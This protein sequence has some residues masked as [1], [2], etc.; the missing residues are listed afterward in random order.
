MKLSN[1]ATALDLENELHDV[2]R[3]IRELN[4]SAFYDV[5][6]GNEHDGIVSDNDTHM[7][8][9]AIKDLKLTRKRI[10]E[11]LREICVFE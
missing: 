10:I 6:V 11:A 7:R 3:Q 9:G 1:L 2:D 4:E 5:A 8:A